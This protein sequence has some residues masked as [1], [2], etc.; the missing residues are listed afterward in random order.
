MNKKSNI[1]IPGIILVASIVLII[2]NVLKN[3]DFLQSSLVQ[4]LS[5]LTVILVSYFLVQLRNDKSKK[6]EKINYLLSKI[7]NIILNEDFIKYQSKEDNQKTLIM[8]RT[9]GNKITLLKECENTDENQELISLVDD[10]FNKLKEFYGDHGHDATY[11]DN[12][13]KEVMNYISII[14]DACDKLHMLLT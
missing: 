12:S 14:D 13:K 8:I 10:T 3:D 11:M 4:I 1:F 5:L 9:V 6:N 7:Q 2:Y